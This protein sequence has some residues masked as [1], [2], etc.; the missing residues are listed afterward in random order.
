MRESRKSPSPSTFGD[1]VLGKLFGFPQCCI[2]FYCESPSLVRCQAKG[3]LGYRF[4]PSCSD[5]SE[6]EVIKSINDNRICPVPFPYQPSMEH[7]SDILQSPHWTEIERAWLMENRSRYMRTDH[8]LLDLTAAFH[9]E[10]SVLDR[11][12]NE[13]VQREPERKMY[14]MALHEK[15]RHELSMSLLN[16]VHEE[17]SHRMKMTLR[18]PKPSPE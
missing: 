3:F 13:D 5:R 11:Q 16:G 10:M 8:E 15:R 18:K 17:F 9:N 14:L 1:R 2:D 6:E 4:C 12:L 7:L